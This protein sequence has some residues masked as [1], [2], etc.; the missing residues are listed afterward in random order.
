[1]AAAARAI[2]PRDAAGNVANEIERAANPDPMN[3]ASSRNIS[4][5]HLAGCT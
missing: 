2:L 3:L 1:M 4:P 5:D